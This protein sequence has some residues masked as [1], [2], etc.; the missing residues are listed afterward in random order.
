M[1]KRKAQL[2]T[3]LLQKLYEMKSHKCLLQFEAATQSPKISQEKILKGT[4]KSSENTLFG[5]QHF[6]STIETVEQ[7]KQKVPLSDFDSMRE[8]ME[9]V[10]AGHKHVLTTNEVLMLECTSGSASAN[11]LIPYTKGLFREFSNATTPWLLSFFK[12]YPELKGTKFY[13]SISASNRKPEFSSG[14]LRIGLENDLEYLSSLEKWAWS[15]MMAVPLSVSKASDIEDWKRKTSLAL[16]QCQNL[17]LISVWSPTFL[18]VLFEY[19]E[20]NIGELKAVLPKSTQKKLTNECFSAEGLLQAKTVWP[21]LQVISCWTDGVSGQFLEPLKLRCRG[22]PIEGKG[23]LAT[24]GVVSINLFGLPDPVGAV[25]SHFLEF[26]PSQLLT[27]NQPLSE[28]QSKTKEL[29]ELEPSQLYTPVLT[30]SGGLYRYILK[31]QVL[32]TGKHNNTPLLRFMGKLDRIS[33]MC[34]EKLSA[35]FLEKCIASAAEKSGLTFDFLIFSPQRLPDARYVLYIETKCTQLKVEDFVSKVEANMREGKHY[36]YCRDL[37]QLKSLTW[38]KV[39]EGTAKYQKELL[40]LG[41][42]LGNIKPSVLELKADWHQVFND[43][44]APH[45]KESAP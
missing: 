19:I 6:F 33:D 44:E 10:Y 8:M 11:K 24:E 13:I 30:T 38:T 31:D 39:T 40:N 5:R 21:K 14:G 37:G 23:L 15:K 28:M 3:Y 41:M 1:L 45:K 2:I 36:D 22:V 42:K 35:V 25:N 18:T 20:K 16:L 17:G 43:F 29:H 9:Q 4:L 26:L 27:E 12:R 34:G 32:C 7:F